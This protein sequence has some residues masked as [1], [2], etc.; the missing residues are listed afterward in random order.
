M[1]VVVFHSSV[2]RRERGPAVYFAG[3]GVDEIGAVDTGEI[4][5]HRELAQR[6]TI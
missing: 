6:E 4:V 1:G 5:T 2:G 3:Q